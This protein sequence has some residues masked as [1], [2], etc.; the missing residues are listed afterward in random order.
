MTNAHGAGRLAAIHASRAGMRAKTATI[1]DIRGVPLIIPCQEIPPDGTE[2]AGFITPIAEQ[3]SALT[4][5]VPLGGAEMLL[6]VPKGEARIAAMLRAEMPWLAPAIDHIARAAALALWAGQP[7]LAF[8]PLLLVGPPG[9]GKTHFANRLAELA[10]VGS[11]ALSLAGIANNAELAGSP[12]GFKYPQPSLAACTIGRSGTGNPV[13]I[14]DE[15]EKAGGS[16]EMGDARQTLLTFLE[17]ASARAHFDG[18]LAAPIDLSH[19]NWILTANSVHGLSG[20]LLS[21][22]SVIE[23]AGPAPEHAESVLASLLQAQAARWDLPC[24]A[25]PALDR[26][27]EDE[28]LAQF[29]RHRSVRRMRKALA[30]ILA[31]AAREHVHAIH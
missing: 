22:L 12:R 23:V 10:G 20:P 13:I 1:L 19:V 25:F 18:C 9:C 28:L 30:S 26:A 11:A 14:I 6:A 16:P 2:G 3:W 27:I 17:P 24:S 31:I 15:V 7:W 21:R 5:P 29:R 4:R 8:P